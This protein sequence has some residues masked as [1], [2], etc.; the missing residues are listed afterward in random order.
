MFHVV[1]EKLLKIIKQKL[2][3]DSLFETRINLGL[4]L[5]TT[6]FQ[7]VNN[8]YKQHFGCAMSF[9]WSSMLSNTFMDYL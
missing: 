1:I 9:S 2:E 6:Y 3:L 7:Y 5:K 8:F 4:Y